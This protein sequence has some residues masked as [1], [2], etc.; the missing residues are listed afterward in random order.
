[1]GC[2]GSTFEEDVFGSSNIEV[3]DALPALQ[4]ALEAQGFVAGQAQH[5]GNAATEPE[6]WGMTVHQFLAFIGACRNTATWAQ[7][8]KKNSYV[9]GYDLCD[10]FAVLCVARADLRSKTCAVNMNMKP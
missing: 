5:G 2:A 7:L 9:S 8:K 3:P 1:M 4:S 10:H 6:E